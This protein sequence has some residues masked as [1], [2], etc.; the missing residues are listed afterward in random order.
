M[1]IRAALPLSP[2]RTLLVACLT[3]LTA[4]PTVAGA[5]NW[6]YTVRPGD[7]LWSVAEKYLHHVGY[8]PRL[9]TLNQVADPRNLPPGMRLRLPVAWMKRQP[10]RV[11][12]DSVSGPA[13]ATIPP[14]NRTRALEPGMQLPA[15]TVLDTGA[16]ATVVLTFADGSRFTLNQASR[17]VLDRVSA[18]GDSGM[19]DIGMRLRQGRVVGQVDPDSGPGTRFEISSPASQT[20][21]RGTD[22]RVGFESGQQ[23]AR[24]EVLDGRVTVSG[25]G[26]TRTLRAGT[27]TIAR[28]GEPPQPPRRLL[29]P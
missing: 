10:A 28:T 14:E 5:A 20:A 25:A 18:Y 27:G 7:T 29:P 8:V 13:T 3:L 21:V 22:F 26:R 19:V 4:L 16:G 24:T 11:R 6:L 12:V 15:D 9:Q 17:V 2:A 23:T 1:A